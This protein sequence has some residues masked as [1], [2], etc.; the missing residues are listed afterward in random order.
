MDLQETETMAEELLSEVLLREKETDLL[1]TLETE[2]MVLLVTEIILLVR[3][4]DEEEVTLED[5]L[6]TENQKEN[7]TEREW[8][9]LVDQFLLEMLLMKTKENLLPD[10]QN[11]P[12]NLLHP[13]TLLKDNL[14]LKEKQRENLQEK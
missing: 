14:L 9:L 11:L 7:Q 10:N 8:F 12:L 1:E 6:V 2:T 5:L 13:K 4:L 3:A